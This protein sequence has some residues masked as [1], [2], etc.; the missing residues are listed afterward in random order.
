MS[1]IK[2]NRTVEEKKEMNRIRSLKWRLKNPGETTSRVREW[3][4]NNPEEAKVNRR[5]WAK[6]NP[7]KDKVSKTNYAARQ[8]GVIGEFT[9]AEWELLLKQYG[10]ICPRCKKECQNFTVDHIIPISKGG[11]NFIENIQPLCRSC[12]SSKKANAT[13]Y[14]P[15]I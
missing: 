6:E 5:R 2:L 7:I 12:N 13:Y 10:N 9:F 15:I 4:K 14:S 11:S 1:R 8:K 3:R